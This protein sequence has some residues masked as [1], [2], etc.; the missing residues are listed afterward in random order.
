MAKHRHK[1]AL[2]S[3]IHCSFFILHSYAADAAYVQHVTGDVEDSRRQFPLRVA[4]GETVDL[5]I[6]FL[7]GGEPLDISGAEVT[8]HTRTNGMSR[9]ESWQTPGTATNH[10]ALFVLDVDAVLPAPSGEWSCVATRGGRTLARLGGPAYVRGTAAASAAA[11]PQDALAGYATTGYVARAVAGIDIPSTNG[12]IRVEADPTVPAWAKAATPPITE[13]SDPVWL[14]QRAG[15]ATT[16]DLSRAAEA[17]SD[18]TAWRIADARA[19]MAVRQDRLARLGRALD[20]AAYTNLTPALPYNFRAVAPLG[21]DTLAFAVEDNSA[22]VVSAS[23]AARVP[24]PAD[25]LDYPRYVRAALCNGRDIVAIVRET[26]IF[27]SPAGEISWTRAAAPG[28]MDPTGI[29]Y[30]PVGRVWWVSSYQGVFCSTNMADWALSLPGEWRSICWGKGVLVAGSASS[31]GLWFARPSGADADWLPSNVTNFEFRA[32]ACNGSEFVA[33]AYPVTNAAAHGG[34]EL[35]PGHANGIYRSRDGAEWELASDVARAYYGFSYGAGVWVGLVAQDGATPAAVYSDTGGRTWHGID[36][37]LDYTLSGFYRDGRIVAGT[38]NPIGVVSFGITRRFRSDY[39]YS[40]PETDARISAAVAAIP[41]P[42]E[43]DPTVPA[44]AKAAQPP[45]ESDPT[46][47]EWAK[48]SNPPSVTET[49]PT[50]PAWAKAAQPPAESDPT[51]PAWAKAAQPPEPGRTDVTSLNTVK[52]ASGV[53]TLS[54]AAG[55]TLTATTNSPAW[56]DGGAVFARV[57]PAGAYSVAPG[58]QLLGYGDWPTNSAE[59]VFVRSGGD[60]LCSVLREGR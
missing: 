34:W 35:G 2:A 55:A 4:R 12:F 20:A 42:V 19:G 32:V 23:G 6:D 3:I 54:I 29:A 16:G 40:K 33:G 5:S 8:L 46:V 41:E 18:D 7:D 10:S 1:L 49:D 59:A 28:G 9:A 11:L 24:S 31:G 48:A 57:S 51:V 47:P 36:G 56:P 14:S 37:M 43:T 22:H 58:I 15:Y 25:G 17:I 53:L 39:L 21:T 13:E 38:Q 26:G 30:D 27:H 45:A 60:I 50:V 44:W 52:Y